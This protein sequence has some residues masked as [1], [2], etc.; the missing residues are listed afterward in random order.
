MCV[1]ALLYSIFP[2][3]PSF[4]RRLPLTLL[5]SPFF[6][7]NYP[8]LAHFLLYSYVPFSSLHSS[9]LPF[10]SLL[11]SFIFNSSFPSPCIPLLIIILFHPLFHLLYISF[12]LLFF[13]FLL[14]LLLSLSVPSFLALSFASSSFTPFSSFLSIPSN[15]TLSLSF[16]F[17]SLPTSYPFPT[18][19]SPS[20]PSLPLHPFPQPPSRPSD[21]F[22]IIKN[23]YSVKCCQIYIK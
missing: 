3:L 20:P 17:P 16:F 15:I 22:P 9:S 19:F 12:S 18:S 11:P 13:L 10:S 5:A 2:L 14:F 6:L 21:S 1:C 4:P 7:F 8:S 23:S